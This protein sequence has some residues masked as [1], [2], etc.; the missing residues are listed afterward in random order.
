MDTDILNTMTITIFRASD[1]DGFIYDIYDCEA[2]EIDDKDA[3]DGGQCTSDDIKDA[4]GM[5]KSQALDLII[6]Q[7]YD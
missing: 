1:G 6:K 4:L 3:L 2:S 7:K 5:A